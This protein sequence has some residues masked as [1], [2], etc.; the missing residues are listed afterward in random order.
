VNSQ[1]K[2][3]GVNTAVISYAQGLCFA[4]SSNLAAYVAGQLIIHGK[5]FRAQLGIAVQTVNLTQRIIA[6]NHLTTKTGSYV[7]EVNKVAGIQNQ[8]IRPGDIIVSFEDKPVASIDLLHK[9]LDN[10]V[11]GQRIAL[12]ILRGGRKQV[13]SVIPGELK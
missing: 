6:A 13:V 11:I 7:F 2:V 4:V 3:I 12:G 9:Y 5:V 8:E 10:E 1:G